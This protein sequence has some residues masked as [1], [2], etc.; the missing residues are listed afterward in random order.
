M[1]PKDGALELAGATPGPGTLLDAAR[2]VFGERGFSGAYH[3]R[4]ARPLRQIRNARLRAARAAQVTR[5]G[6]Q[7][8]GGA[9]GGGRSLPVRYR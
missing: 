4:D 3:R 6:P 5:R 1:K 2:E 9:G 8:R 7:P